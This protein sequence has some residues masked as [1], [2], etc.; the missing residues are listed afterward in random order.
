MAIVDHDYC[1]WYTDIGSS[2]RASDG[3]VF[4]SCTI[5]GALENNLLP[6]SGVIVGDDAFPLK[7]YLMKP[8]ARTAALTEKEKIFNYRLSR[9]R[10]ISENAFGIFVSRFRLFEKPINC[11]VDTVD[12]LV[13]AACTLHN[14]LR[15]TSPNRYMPRGSIDEEDIAT[16]NIILGSWR[17]E[18]GTPLPRVQ[19]VG[20]PNAQSTAKNKRNNY[21]DYFADKGAVDWQYRMIY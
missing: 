16:G 20:G 4:G 7:N 12:K 3:G 6:D 18:I 5:F 2:G 14:W 19:R 21:A 10:R 17:S 1:F 11:C 15:H 13:K 9:A 8:Y